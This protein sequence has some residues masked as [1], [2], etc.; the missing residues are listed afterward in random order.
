MKGEI[1]FSFWPLF[2]F[3]YTWRNSHSP[4]VCVGWDHGDRC[5]LK[6]ARRA[7]LHERMVSQSSKFACLVPFV[8]TY[9]YQRCKTFCVNC[10]FMIY[11]I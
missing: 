5:G 10:V 3:E 2:F 8:S 4:A 7:S 1:S 6:K 11:L 9:I